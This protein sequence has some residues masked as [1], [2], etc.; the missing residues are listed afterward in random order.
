MVETPEGFV[1]AVL[2]EIDLPDPKADPV[3]Y[4]QVQQAL[5]HAMADDLQ[6][7]YATAVRDRAS[8]HVNE[9]AVASLA[10][11]GE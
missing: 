6:N 1:V 4:G 2:S 11:P 9:A 10:T 7:V 5:A 8:P 3:G